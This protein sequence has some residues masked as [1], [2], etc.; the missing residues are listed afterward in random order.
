MPEGFYTLSDKNPA[1][2]YY[3]AMLVSYPN[4]SDRILGDKR[5][6][7]GEI[8]IHGGCGS[9]GCLAMSDDRI[10][11]IWVATTALRSAGGVVQVHI[12]PTRDMAGLL[13]KAEGDAHRPFWE[14]LQEG[15]D[16]FEKHRKI[17]FIRVDRR[18]RYLFH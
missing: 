2:N 7:G 3:L 1:T 6:P 13:A 4:L 12:Y 18:G 10:Q 5:D 16:H 8:M 15:F 11:E 14:N 9:V 17:G